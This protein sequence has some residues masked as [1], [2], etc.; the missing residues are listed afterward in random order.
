[1]PKN[2]NTIPQD[3][4]INQFVFVSSS[5]QCRQQQRGRNGQ[6]R[7]DGRRCQEVQDGPVRQSRVAILGEGERSHRGNPI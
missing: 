1:M 3:R 4:L 2:L 7:R 6:C 5:K